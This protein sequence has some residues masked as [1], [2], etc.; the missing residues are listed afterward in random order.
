VA[1]QTRLWQVNKS[2]DNRE[3]HPAD[4]WDGA[5]MAFPGGIDG[6]GGNKKSGRQAAASK[7]FRTLT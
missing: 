3:I 1:G 6:C 5:A 2:R 7:M 4:P